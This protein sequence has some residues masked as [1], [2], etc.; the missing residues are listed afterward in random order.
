MFNMIILLCS[1][2]IGVAKPCC[3][4]EIIVIVSE[5]DAKLKLAL[6]SAIG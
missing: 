5:S 6:L 2:R 1:N 3:G 4:E